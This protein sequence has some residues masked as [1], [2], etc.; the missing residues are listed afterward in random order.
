MNLWARHMFETSHNR[1][2]SLRKWPYPYQ[3]GITISNDAEFMSFEF[4]ETLMSYLNTQTETALG[5]GLGLEVTSS[6]FHYS[7]NPYNFSVFGGAEPYA[8]RSEHASRIEEYLRAGWIDTLHAY[9]DFDHAGGF[10]RI[11]AEN[12][13]EHLKQIG[14]S[15]YA[16]TN[17]GGVENI[18]NVGQDADY[19][20]GDHKGH[21]A[22]HTDLWN[23]IGIRYVWTD[24]MVAHNLATPP[25]SIRK[26]LTKFRHA[27]NGFTPKGY[28][29]PQDSGVLKPIVLN[30][31]LEVYGFRRY[32]GTGANAPNLSSLGYQVS[33]IPWRKFYRDGE[34]LVI[35]QHFGVLDRLNGCCAPA[36]IEAVKQ[37][38]EMYL[39]PFRFLAKEFAE[40]RLWVLGCARFLDYIRLRD[41]IDVAYDN[42]G[43]VHLQL[44]AIISNP[45]EELQGVTIYIDPINFRGLFIKGSQITV[46]N[47]GPDYTGRYS[48]TVPVQKLSNIWN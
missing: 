34:A 12:C 44:K 45:Q 17:H 30:D 13:L 46:Q 10:E 28:F 41:Q 6:V 48:V 47:N 5:R 4:F 35:Y 1:N 40:G 9:G 19:H 18:Q 8:A 29:L 2:K 15:I 39:E 23:D 14:V 24:S 38:P 25:L 42:D 16:F 11:H 31:K 7:A 22:Y 33:Q 3:A 32:R 21:Q 43:S 37:R 20:R 26:R 36:S 27:F